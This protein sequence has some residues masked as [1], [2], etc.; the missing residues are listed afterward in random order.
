MESL[1]DILR[2]LNLRVYNYL[3]FGPDEVYLD[4]SEAMLTAV[5]GIN[6]DT[7]GE[8]SRNGTGKSALL[9]DAIAYALFGKTIRDDIT[10][11]GLVHKLARK[12]QPMGVHLEYS[13]GPFRYLIERG[14][15]PSRLLFFRKP[16]DDERD[17]RTRAKVDGKLVYI[18]D[19]TQN[20]TVT[21]DKIIE[22][23]GF[24]LTLFTYLVGL[25]SEAI[26]F[27][28]LPEAQRRAVVESLFGFTRLTEI[29]KFIKKDRDAKKT[30]V[31]SLEGGLQATVAANARIQVQID[32]L[33]LKQVDYYKPIEM[34][35]KQA[36]LRLGN[37]IHAGQ[38]LCVEFEKN[39]FV[40]SLPESIRDR[41]AHVA[42]LPPGE[43]ELER[44]TGRRDLAE[45]AVE[46]MVTQMERNAADTRRELIEAQTSAIAEIALNVT[47]L[48]RLNE[49]TTS[50]PF[51]RNQ[52][53]QNATTI[54]RFESEIANLEEQIVKLDSSLCPAC[55]QVTTEEH[56]TLEHGRLMAKLESFFGEYENFVE[57]TEIL[58]SRLIEDEKVLT[59]LRASRDVSVKAQKEIEEKYAAKIAELDNNL[60]T[61]LNSE[62]TLLNLIEEF[63]TASEICEEA[64][65]L[66]EARKSAI[67]LAKEWEEQNVETNR[68]TEIITQATA[69]MDPTINPDPYMEQIVAL[70]TN[71]LI[72]I[73]A[74]RERLAEAQMVLDHLQLLIELATKPDSFIRKQLI[75]RWLPKLNSM[76]AGFLKELEL[77]HKVRFDTEMAI[78]VEHMRG[79]YTNGNLSKGERMRLV[80]AINLAFQ[81]LYETMNNPINLLAIDELLDSGICNRGAANA[82]RI[83][84]AFVRKHK[85]RAFIITHRSDIKDRVDSTLTVVKE[86]DI[87]TIKWEK[88]PVRT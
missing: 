17:F 24:D 27:T 13:R 37:L 36:E 45:A 31:T 2:F 51:S 71:A 57:E 5:I 58:R 85:K 32:A 47:D 69:D 63:A 56:R 43:A 10:N 14:E 82:L 25:T 87:S 76:I 84:N 38:Q 79:E 80:V 81:R 28:K 50:I 23:V 19:Q 40:Q 61:Q 60:E 29:A 48:D 20:K 26:P 22:S 42:A 33:R 35:K 68:L 9:I 53:A 55:G 64:Q 7:G 39:T 44:L 88:E 73:R 15:N 34:R 75:A 65:R 21:G 78:H 3:S 59:L 74:E 54:K 46:R 8:D 12:G 30:E 67:A 4:L 18:F 66:A 49:L 83:L 62:P 77:P 41:F 70:E 86:N 1:S 11:K 52:C 6:H 16:Y 72:D